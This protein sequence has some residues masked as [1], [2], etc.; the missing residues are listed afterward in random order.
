LAAKDG[1]NVREITLATTKW[2]PYTCFE[3]R[4]EFGVVGLYI[5]KLLSAYGIK[6][7]I[8][9]YPWSRA[10]RLAENR[11][12]DGLLT[13]THSEAPGLIFSQSAVASYQMCFYTLKVNKW[14]FNG[15]LDFDTNTLAV[16]K[17]YSYE[18]SLDAYIKN[19][20]KVIALFGSDATE[21]LIRLLLS[22]RAD[23]IAVDKLVLNYVSANKSIDVSNIKDV[24]CLA[25]SNFYLALAPTIANKLLLN[26]LDGDLILKENKDFFNSLVSKIYQ[27]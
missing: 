18:Q 7:S 4:K 21:R 11:M 17:D 20:S 24:G 8:D 14:Q 12:V 15:E 22:G 5:N 2:C 3:S 9:S 25:K 16:I 27:Q 23:I 10:I 26:K 19:N 1:N 13:A 6:L